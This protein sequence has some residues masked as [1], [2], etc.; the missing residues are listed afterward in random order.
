MTDLF[1]V[2]TKE[3]IRALWWRQPY[4]SLMLHG[5]V[6]TRTWNTP[7]RG[8]VLICT[9]MY[10]YQAHDV[11]SLSGPHWSATIAD[12]LK[13]EPTRDLHGHAIAIGRLY[14]CHRMRFGDSKKAFVEWNRD[15]YCH[16]YTDIRRI[17]PF[18]ILGSQGWRTLDDEVK[19]KIT[20]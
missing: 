19:Q 10:P 17:T 20:A 1:G 2:E 6:E 7:Y 16:W 8:K 13:D 18:K 15:L 3:E 9:S 5:K 12:I 14:D 11:N 4:G